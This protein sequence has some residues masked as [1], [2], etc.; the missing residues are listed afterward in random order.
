[1]RNAPVVR[2]PVP[3]ANLQA[4]LAALAL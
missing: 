2:K 3:F 1:M 4:A